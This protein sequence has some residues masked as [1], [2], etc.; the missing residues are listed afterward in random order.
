MEDQKPLPTSTTVD[1]PTPDFNQELENLKKQCEE[2]LNGWKRAQADYQNLKKET[3]SKNQE[4]ANFIQASLLLEILP[5]IN[6]LK[7]A[8][9]HIPSEQKE[10][11]W[12]KG[13]AHIY[14]QFADWLK[15]QGIEQI[16]TIGEK[17]NPELHEAVGQETNEEV[18]DYIIVKEI[19]PGYLL[20]KTVINPAKVVVNIKK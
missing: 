8:L 5:I 9:G 10:E 16:K 2:Y 18:E 1:S 4:L 19:S 6:N 14:R 3:A 17:F 13:I 15:N 11:A 20:N 12:V 7:V